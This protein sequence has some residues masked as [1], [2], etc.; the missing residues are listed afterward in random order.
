MVKRTKR[1]ATYA[2]L[3]ALPPHLTA[4]IIDGE[5][6][7][8]PAAGPRERT[9]PTELLRILTGAVDRNN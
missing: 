2:D 3:E 1:P 8:R 6:F 4:E 7:T 5:L 9:A